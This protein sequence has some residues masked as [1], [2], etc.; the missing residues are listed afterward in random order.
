[1]AFSLTICAREKTNIKFGGTVS[2]S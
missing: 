2:W 1:M